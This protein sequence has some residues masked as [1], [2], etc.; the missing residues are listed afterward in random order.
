MIWWY[1]REEE[2]EAGPPTSV[3]SHAPLSS[4]HV[5]KGFEARPEEGMGNLQLQGGRTDRTCVYAHR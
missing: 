5:D 4:N 3:T 2:K 1:W